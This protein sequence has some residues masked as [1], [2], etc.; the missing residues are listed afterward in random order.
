M[1]QDVGEDVISQYFMGHRAFK[2]QDIV[3]ASQCEHL[4]RWT[5]EATPEQCSA[6]CMY[7]SD[8]LSESTTVTVNVFQHVHATQSCTFDASAFAAQ[9]RLAEAGCELCIFDVVTR[10]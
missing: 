1:W 8:R 6:M 7:T 10:H 5:D 3:L 4:Q 9:H 2:A